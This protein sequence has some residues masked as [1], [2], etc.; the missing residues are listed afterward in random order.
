VNMRKP[1]DWDENE[2]S[3]PLKK[4]KDKPWGIEARYTGTISFI[5]KNWENHKWYATEKA[6]DTALAALQSK[7]RGPA[8]HFEY[9]KAENEG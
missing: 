7:L 4:K 9:R 2:V 3:E 8:K 5:R 1:F 6:R